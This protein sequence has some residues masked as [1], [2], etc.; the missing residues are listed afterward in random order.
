LIRA[1]E[2][3][4]E[5]FKIHFNGKVV[6][7]F[8]SSHYSGMNNSTACIFVRYGRVRPMIVKRGQI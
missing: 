1:H 8:S 7:V 5:G 2:C 4:N 6:T 3:V